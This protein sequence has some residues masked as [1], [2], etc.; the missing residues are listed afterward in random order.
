VAPKLVAPPRGLAI[1]G[2]ASLAVGAVAGV[3]ALRVL[4]GAPARDRP[5]PSREGV[6]GPLRVDRPA[7]AFSGR[8]LSGRGSLSLARYRGSTVVVSF[9]ASWCGPCRSEVP[10]LERLW[11]TYR[12]RGVVVVGVDY[13][14]P[15]PAA[16]RFARSA[17][18]TY[19]SV[20]DSAGTIGDAYRIFGLPD[21]FI[22]G[23]DGRLRYVVYGKISPSS[24]RAALDS[25]VGAGRTGR[26][27]QTATGSSAGR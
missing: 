9:W 17:G 1:L 8:L 21:T 24:F 25:V 16:L 15:A 13:A 11:R 18:M 20:V 4:G 26:Q 12:D 6:G 5:A 10:E 19:P 27:G 7:P 3:V 14:D 23:P 2:A 22:V